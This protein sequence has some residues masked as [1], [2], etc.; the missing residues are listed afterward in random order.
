MR[1]HTLAIA[2]LTALP[3][4]AAEAAGLGGSLASM[5]LQHTVAEKSDFTFLKTAAQVRELVREHLL[6]S[7]DSG[8]NLTLSHV[9]FPYARADVK[10]FVDRIAAQY[11]AFTGEPL[12]VTSLTRPLAT[13]PKNA[14]P[15]S[16][17][18]TGMA[19]DF[20]IPSSAVARQ[21]LEGKLLSLEGKGVLDV[22]RERNPA[23]YHVAVFPEKY[24]SYDGTLPMESA[25]I[26]MSPT[27]SQVS[28]STRA[29]ASQSAQPLF[30]MLSAAG[31]GATG[32]GCAAWRRRPRRI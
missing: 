21:W 3:L 10:L 27:V 1:L 30:V 7:V 6:V 20:R 17:H 14:H 16:V 8:A 28:T 32:L 2:L 18:P 19:V 13:Q 9:S 29:P 22:T 24:A 5:R 23:H 12:V 26:P 11:R 31:L 15:L 4:G 25:T